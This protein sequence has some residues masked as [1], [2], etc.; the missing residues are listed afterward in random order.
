LPDFFKEM[1]EVT[2]TSADI[3]GRN[4]LVLKANNCEELMYYT[5]DDE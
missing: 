3:V 4:R 2:T 5:T 1:A